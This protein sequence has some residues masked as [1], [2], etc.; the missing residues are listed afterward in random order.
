MHRTWKYLVFG[1]AFCALP[2]LAHAHSLPGAMVGWESGF[3]HPLE[4]WDHWLAMVGVGLWAAQ[5]RGRALWLLPASFVAVMALGACAGASGVSLR[6]VETAI[7]L[8]V[9]VIGALVAARVRLPLSVSV[10][11]V[12]FFAF[13]H[14]FAHG[15]ELPRSAGIVGFG[16]G[17][18]AAT[19]LLHALGLGA[20]RIAALA[21]AAL[22]SAVAVAQEADTSDSDAPVRLPEVV[23]EGRSD[24]LVGVSDSAS[25]GTVGA[26]QLDERP[27]LRP[28]EVLET[29]PGLIVTQHSGEGKANQY[30]LRG[31]NLD[32][33]T[34]FATSVNG[35]PVNL[36]THG[37]GQG[38]TD[39]N[40]MIPELVHTVNYKKG[41][42][43]ADEGDFSS[44]GAADLE[45]FQVLPSSIASVQFGMYD[46]FRALLAASPEVAGGHLLYAGEVVFDDGPWKSPADFLKGN[47]VLGYSRGGQELGW[48]LTGMAYKGSWDST[49]QIARRAVDRHNIT[50]FGALDDSDGGESQRYGLTGEWHR[51]E[52]GQATKLLA[53]LYYYDLNLF[54]NFTY[55]LLDHEHGDQIN[56]KD[57]RWVSGLRASQSWQWNLAG[58]ETDNTLGLQFRNDTVSNA[59]LHTERRKRLSTTR[60]D[61]VGEFS[62]SPYLE[63]REQWTPWLRSTA[64]VRLDVFHFDVDSNL[65]ENE[66]T[67][68]KSIVSPKLALVA[69]PWQDTEVYLNGG[70]GFHSNDGRGTTT[71]V[72]PASGLRVSPVDPLVRTY[73]A[74]LGV[75]STF[76]PHLQ[77]TVA[78]WWLDIDSELVF[79]GDAGATEA[80]RPSQRYGLEWTNFYTPT[81]WLTFD[82]DFAFTRA[83]FRNSAPEGNY[84]PG[85][86]NAVIGAGVTLHD[87]GGPFGSLRLRY[88]GPRALVENDAVRSGSTT[89][90]NAQLGYQFNETWTATVD[91]FNLLNSEDDD[92]SYFY[93]SRLRYESPGP[94]PDGGYNDIQ[95]HPVEP[96]S[97]RLTLSARF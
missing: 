58:F 34:D 35:V 43:Y 27:L 23:V 86:P 4:G 57:D 77:S 2:S 67:K 32:H 31:F 22:L 85:S 83:Q 80:S 24:S 42:Y 47:L 48:S 63:M 7:L 15:A 37:H 91:V 73:G 82:A 11:L 54:S 66:G 25:E 6:G 41:V 8:S 49:D 36:P 53:F 62:V 75:R 76:I 50:R 9:A 20:A 18:V 1:V 90:V 3:A 97:V 96:T 14:G 33:G 19:L 12:G 59:L 13:F 26:K 88:F 72:D 74:E 10:C 40:F 68:T 71:T 95:F 92:I 81:E 17:F 64:G 28:G 65:P 61:D 60:S 38:Y 84:I 89:L 21:F 30:F 45:Y 51:D 39:L 56:Q 87:L 52:A 46:E 44:A 70:L 78:F 5:R 94:E 16:L 79:V 55:N 69:G 93:E 29:V